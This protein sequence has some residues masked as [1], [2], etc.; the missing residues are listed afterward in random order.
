M[1]RACNLVQQPAIRAGISIRSELAEAA[2]D[3]LQL[4]CLVALRAARRVVSTDGKPGN[5][6]GAHGMTSRGVCISCWQRGPKYFGS[7]LAAV[8]VALTH[9]AV[10]FANVLHSKQHAHDT[11]R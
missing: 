8:L 3:S 6:P 10:R 5:V 4:H 7:D 9:K 11:V 2:L 1:T